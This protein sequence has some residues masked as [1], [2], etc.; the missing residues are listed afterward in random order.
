M[1]KNSTY[2]FIIFQILALVC[3][4]CL[5]YQHAFSQQ[6]HVQASVDK[7]SILIGDQITLKL[8]ATYNPQQF[9]VQFPTINDTFNHF[10]LVKKGKV[11]TINNANDISISQQTIITSFDSGQWVIP[12]LQFSAKPMH[13]D[14]PFVVQTN[15]IT[16]QVQTIVVDTAKPFKPIMGIRAASIPMSTILT[17]AAI[18]LLLIGAV[19]FGI[20]YFIK[21]Q[22]EKNKNKSVKTSEIILLPHE[23]AIQNL[24]KIESKKLWQAGQEKLYYTEVTDSLRLYLEEQFS[25]DCFEKTTSEIIQQVKKQK[26]LNPYRQVLRDL[27]QLADLVK[28]A[29]GK[30]TENEHL[31]TMEQAKEFVI[32]SFKKHTT[33]EELLSQLKNKNE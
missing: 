30:P 4:I 10:E 17:Y 5:S 8:E 28:F 9:I 25:I 15:P 16:I 32:A 33:N 3:F 27:F 12:P 2:H 21:K 29:K 20:W 7:T 31:Q 6:V 23:K 11:D 18:G 22:R 26:I 13:G 19:L 14:T 24:T 1:K